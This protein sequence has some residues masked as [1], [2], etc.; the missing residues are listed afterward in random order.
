MPERA[1]IKMHKGAALLEADYSKGRICRRLPRGNLGVFS[2]PLITSPSR[3]LFLPFF[4]SPDFS[5]P[6]LTPFSLFVSPLAPMLSTFATTSLPG[7]LITFPHFSP[8]PLHISRSPLSSFCINS[9]PSCFFIFSDCG[10]LKQLAVEVFR[11]PTGPIVRH[12]FTVALVVTRIGFRRGEPW[13]SPVC[14]ALEHL[15]TPT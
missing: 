11:A 5:L 3:Y 13:R 2:V 1:K 14:R 7:P 4:R 12:G 6:I 8:M 15:P 9:Y 10:H